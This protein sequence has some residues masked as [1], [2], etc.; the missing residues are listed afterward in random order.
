[1]QQQTGTL[2]SAFQKV[3]KLSHAAMLAMPAFDIAMY[4]REGYS[5][6]AAI[7]RGLGENA[8]FM[9]YPSLMWAYLA[10]QV[11]PAVFAAGEQIYRQRAS[12]LRTIANRGFI[13]GGYQDTQPAYTMRQQ[14]ERA[15]RESFARVV[16]GNEARM[17]ARG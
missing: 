9:L 13:G 16:Y 8:L 10:A 17:F 1:M 3:G 15:I 6:P 5:W 4:R 7:A 14:G 2:K 11:G 12:L